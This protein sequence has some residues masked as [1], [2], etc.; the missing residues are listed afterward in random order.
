MVVIYHA[1]SLY[2]VH[3]IGPECCSFTSLVTYYE[4]QL[5]QQISILQRFILEKLLPRARLTKFVNNEMCSG[6]TRGRVL[7]GEIFVNYNY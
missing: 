3:H 6:I 2:T 1:R 7:G 4:V 5:T